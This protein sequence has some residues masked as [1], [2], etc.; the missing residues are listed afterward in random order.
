MRAVVAAI[1][2]GLVTAAVVAL[3]GMAATR[4]CT[5]T[6]QPYPS[7]GLEKAG[8]HYI[9]TAK[10]GLLCNE[11]V[12]VARRAGRTRN[13]GPMVGFKSGI[14]TC[15]SLLPRE[16]PTVVAGQCMKMGA[17]T[18]V[19]VGW[20]AYCPPGKNCKKLDRRR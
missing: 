20:S 11:A 6:G 13:P 3:P 7:V 15:F 16:Y 18:P 5:F 1:A 17:P 10:K 8:H 14:W 19:L 12:A 2:V 4:E 9:V